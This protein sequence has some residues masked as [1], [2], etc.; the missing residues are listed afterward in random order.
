MQP[1]PTNPHYNLI[2]GEETVRRLVDRF[3]QLMDE[4]PEAY[5]IR[6]L[7][8][9]DLSSAKEKLF[10][11]LSGWLGGPPLY[12]QKYG[13]PR[14]RQRHMPFAIG[15]AERDQWMMCMEQAMADVGMDESYREQLKAAFFKTADFMRNREG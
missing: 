4:L 13:H 8:A 14:L 7:H 12:E 11:F 10:E 9:A 3:Y 6:K 5:G 15:E 1:T 2:G